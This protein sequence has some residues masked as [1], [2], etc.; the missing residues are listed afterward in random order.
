MSFIT[1]RLT[2]TL[3]AVALAAAALL[4]S[5]TTAPAAHAA[6]SITVCFWLPDGQLR[7]VEVP[8]EYHRDPNPNPEP[9]MCPYVI[10]AVLEYWED[11]TLADTVSQE[12]LEGFAGL[13]QAR[14]TED[15]AAADRLRAES[16][17]RLGKAA[18]L[19]GRASFTI[20]QEPE[21]APWAVSSKEVDNAVVAGLT[22]LQKAGATGDP[23]TAAWLEQQA[24]AELDFAAETVSKL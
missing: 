15:A 17:A 16:L 13:V 6:T 3:V 8:L 24:A 19:A 22:Y 18:S 21:P 1:T 2:R 14:W 5:V 11:Y 10:N 23:R 20:A 4:G 9:C 7:C 12:V